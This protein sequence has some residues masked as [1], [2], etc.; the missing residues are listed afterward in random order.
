MES[1][2]LQQNFIDLSDTD[3][4]SSATVNLA[5]K[6][7][8]GGTI[9]SDQPDLINIFADEIEQRRLKSSEK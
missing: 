5:N 4:S 1:R 3:T 2:A 7:G 9:T 8:P 6:I